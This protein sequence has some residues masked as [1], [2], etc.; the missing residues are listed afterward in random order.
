M[1]LYVT[2]IPTTHPVKILFTW[3]KISKNFV[4]MQLLLTRH[5]SLHEDYL[6]IYYTHERLVFFISSQPNPLEK[7]QMLMGQ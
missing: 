6:D 3:S 4:T 1:I 7:T 2:L 5:R